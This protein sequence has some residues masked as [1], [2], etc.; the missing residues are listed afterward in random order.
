M[1]NRGNVSI[2]YLKQGRLKMTG[3][4]F[5]PEQIANKLHEADILL[6]Q[7]CTVAEVSRRL[8][9]N[10]HTFYHWRKEYGG[11]RGDQAKRL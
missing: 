6:I 10:D 3:K 11:M 9:I 4:R 8:G 5:K 2:S 1:I 7:G